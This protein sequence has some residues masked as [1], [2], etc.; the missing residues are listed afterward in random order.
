MGLNVIDFNTTAALLANVWAQTD[1][2]QVVARD[3]QKGS[4]YHVIGAGAGS[5][6][7]SAIRNVSTGYLAIPLNSLRLVSG[8][9]D[10]GNIASIG[11]LGASDSAPILRADSANSVEWNW[12]TGNVVALGGDIA[13]P[14]DFDGA[15]AST[16]QLEVY[17]GSTDK[18]S[19]TVAICC[20]GGTETS[21]TADD[22]ATK[23]ATVHTITAAITAA[24]IPSGVNKISLRL[25]PSTAHAT[26]AYQL[27]RAGIL[28]TRK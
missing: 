15:I 17:S 27:A 23:S 18:A 21:Y 26:N 4:A 13:V 22:T 28:Y 25:T 11:G 10:V 5:A 2:F 3:L 7:L 24:D 9:S 19:F 12:A 16:M 14:N 6:Y 8:T 1:V 20:N